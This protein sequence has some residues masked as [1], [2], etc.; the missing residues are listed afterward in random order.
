VRNFG[1]FTDGDKCLF[2]AVAFGAAM[3]MLVGMD[4]GDV[5]G[6]RSSPGGD[7]G[8]DKIKKLEIGRGLC[9]EL[10]HR[11]GLDVYTLSRRALEGAQ[12]ISPCDANKRLEGGHQNA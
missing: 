11:S 4:F 12:N 8:S 5:V 9:Q 6:P 3:A 7:A 2:I 10:I 1:G